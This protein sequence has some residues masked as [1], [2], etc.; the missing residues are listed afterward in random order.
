M[1]EVVDVV[2]PP[3][4]E[5]PEEA[6]EELVRTVLT[7][8]DADGRVAQRFDT[9]DAHL[10][11]VVLDEEQSV[12]ASTFG[13][14]DPIALTIGQAP[15]LVGP[16]RRTA[17]AC[18][19]ATSCN[20]TSPPTKRSA[21]PAIG[22]PARSPDAAMT[23]VVEVDDVTGPP[24]VDVPEEIPTEL[25]VTELEP[26]TG[27]PAAEG[28]TVWVNYTPCSAR[29]APGSPPTTRPSRTR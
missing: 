2:S 11:G 17:S 9:V 6:P 16:L 19:Q 8:G 7:E 24:I 27:E 3:E 14:G 29:T 28:D 20:S 21:R 15:P 1:L 18:A 25:T 13:T 23:F 10:I 22:R 5:L 12:F 26:G 4:F